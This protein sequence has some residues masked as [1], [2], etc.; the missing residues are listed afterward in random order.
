MRPSISNFG[1]SACFIVPL[2]TTIGIGI[3]GCAKQLPPQ[4]ALEKFQAERQLRLDR[5]QPCQVHA[6]PPYQMHI[7]NGQAFIPL[8][9]NNVPT[10]GKLDTGSDTSFITPELAVKAGIDASGHTD[11]FRGITGTFQGGVG[12]TPSIQIGSAT[13][14]GHIPVHVFPFNGQHGTSVGA[15]VGGD[16]LEH[17]DYDMDFP[18]RTIRP[19][20]ISN[21]VGVDPPWRDTYWAVAL[22][23]VAKSI[24][25]T[26]WSDP[27]W[28]QRGAITVPISFPDA[29]LDAAFDT[30]APETLLSYS[31]A[32]DTGVT[33]GELDTDPVKTISG[34]NGHERRMRIHGFKDLAI[35]QEELRDQP[36]LVSPAFDRRDW[37]M[38]LGMDYIAKHR[39]WLSYS[40]ASLYTDSGEQRRP[41]PPLDH[42][43][44]IAGADEPAFPANA[45][46]K[47]GK[48]RISC[49]V[50]A[51]GSITGCHVTE[52]SGDKLFADVALAWL[53]GSDA[54]LM[55]PAFNNG[56]PVRQLHDWQISFAA[57]QPRPPRNSTK[58]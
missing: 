33:A 40:T 24:M 31:A 12:L 29:D 4:T 37:P 26:G 46:G 3:A 47:T 25:K 58:S 19:Y 55:Q 45:A 21:C 42:P 16:W 18:H 11:A 20:H 14:I 30:G 9:I 17:L 44:R 43:H 13:L 50:E 34:M 6:F 7:A 28:L 1:R 10:F 36:L 22:K 2:L 52:S 8:V 48:A 57:P 15:L 56:K 53:Q 38:V 54:P 49:W 32:L 35:G 39:F 5:S 23:R 27:W 41:V 51:D